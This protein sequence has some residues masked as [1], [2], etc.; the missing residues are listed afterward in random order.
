MPDDVGAVLIAVAQEYSKAEVLRCPIVLQHNPKTVPPCRRVDRHHK[1]IRSCLTDKGIDLTPESVVRGGH[2]IR[3]RGCSGGKRKRAIRCR[4]ACRECT[5]ARSIQSEQVNRIEPLALPIL[6]VGS[7]VCLRELADT[8]VSRV[9]NHQPRHI[10]GI[11]EIT[12]VGTG[13]NWQRCAPCS[14][15]PSTAQKYEAGTE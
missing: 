1:A 13:L 5:T 4:S 3:G 2:V 12:M 9:S 11:N 15:T 10:V 6:K 7:P 8:R 14:Y